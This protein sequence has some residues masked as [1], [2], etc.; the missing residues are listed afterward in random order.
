VSGRAGRK[1]KQG[2]VII[3]TSQPDHY[4]IRFLINQ[5]YN[6]FFNL[7]LEERA[8]FKYPP[9][10]RLIKIVVKHKNTTTVNRASAQLADEL[11]KNKSLVVLGPEFPLIAR[12]QLWY[13]KEIW[14]KTDRKL[15]YD[16]VKSF[17]ED[18]VLATK[19]S[20]FN[21]NCI[22]HIDVDPV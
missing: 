3:Q 15:N 19:K 1:H 9:V 5:N 4:I 2:R 8:L 16:Q 21:S 17:I 13:Q 12:I 10:F 7:Q 22:I 18:G 11:R 6:E 20:P 14:I